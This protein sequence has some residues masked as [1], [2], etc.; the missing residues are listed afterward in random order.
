MKKKLVTSFLIRESTQY[1]AI[2]KQAFACVKVF[3]N[4]V[5]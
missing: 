5:S 2:T 1:E 3:L 4:E